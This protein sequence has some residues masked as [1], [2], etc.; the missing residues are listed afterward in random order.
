MVRKI[1]TKKNTEKNG[2]GPSEWRGSI[3]RP[4][5]GRKAR[6]EHLERRLDHDLEVDHLEILG[7]DPDLESRSETP[8]LGLDMLN[9]RIPKINN[10]CHKQLI[11]HATRLEAQ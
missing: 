2:P 10:P 6:V 9:Y 1:L 7:I 3:R 11:I 5:V 8:I 4:V